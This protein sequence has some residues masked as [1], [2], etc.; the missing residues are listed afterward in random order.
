MKRLTLFCF[1]LLPSFLSAAIITVDNKH[2]YVGNFKTLQEAHDAANN[3]DIIYVSP[4]LV[5][6]DGIIVTKQLTFYGVGFDITENVGG[7]LTPTASISGS[8]IFAAGSSGSQL[9]GFDGCFYIEINTSNITI[10]RNDLWRITINTEGQGSSILQNYINNI[11]NPDFTTLYVSDA[12][13]V[14]IAN[15][16][17]INIRGYPSDDAWRYNAVHGGSDLVVK[18]NVIK[19]FGQ[20]WTS[21]SSQITNNIIIAVGGTGNIQGN[22]NFISYNMSSVNSLPARNGNMNNI[23]MNTVFIDIGSYNFHLLPNSPAKGAG[24]NGA[25]MGLYGGDLSYIDSGFPSLPSILQL[26]GDLTAAP[27]TGLNIEFKAKSNK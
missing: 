11:N 18:N 24:E 4:S 13:N 17:I 1:L 8:M 9:E 2:P 15:N 7:A 5:R 12:T 27:G 21:N 20:A 16:E 14:L 6:Y 23:D 10:K 3:G 25:D 22:N 26:H 19:V